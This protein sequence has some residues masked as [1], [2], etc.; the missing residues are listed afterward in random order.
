MSNLSNS[1]SE[2][3]LRFMIDVSYQTG[4]AATRKLTH[5]DEVDIQSLSSFTP[6]REITNKS[7]N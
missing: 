7:E 4:T 3:I 2:V 5:V 1:Y 6:L